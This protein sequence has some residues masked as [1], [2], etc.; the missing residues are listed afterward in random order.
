MRNLG[1]AGL[2]GA[3]Q[4]SFRRRTSPLS[5]TPT[6]RSRNAAGS[7]GDRISRRRGGREEVSRS[8]P[9]FLSHI[10]AVDRA[11]AVVGTTYTSAD[12]VDRPFLF[13]LHLRDGKKSAAK[14]SRARLTL[15]VMGLFSTSFIFSL[16][17]TDAH[18]T[19]S[20]GFFSASLRKL[21]PL[22]HL[23]CRKRKKVSAVEK[24]KLNYFA[25]GFIV[26]IYFIRSSCATSIFFVFVLTYS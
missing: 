20:P 26:G 12:L 5:N 11:A 3:N 13:L 23:N 22:S 8:R 25:S 21:P 6:I 24:D 17:S 1:T 16:D 4:A 15:F 9:S 7:I 18:S 14:G 19:P 10:F 2:K